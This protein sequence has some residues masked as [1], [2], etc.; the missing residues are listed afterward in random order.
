MLCTT[1]FLN[2][3]PHFVLIIH[4][5]LLHMHVHKTLFFCVHSALFFSKIILIIHSWQHLEIH[6]FFTQSSNAFTQIY[7]AILPY[8]HLP[9]CVPLSYEYIIIYIYIFFH[10]CMYTMYVFLFAFST[11]ST[12]LTLVFQ[13][14]VCLID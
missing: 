6:P 8:P 10:F 14:W 3:P 4:R 5:H 1:K 11:A 12:W 7:L 13:I 2:F 9:W